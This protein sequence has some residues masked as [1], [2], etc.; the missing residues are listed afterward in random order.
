MT[1]VLIIGASSGIGLETVSLALIISPPVIRAL[2]SNKIRGSIYHRKIKA[3][4]DTR[5]NNWSK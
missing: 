3:A 1:R 4:H 2:L 5:P